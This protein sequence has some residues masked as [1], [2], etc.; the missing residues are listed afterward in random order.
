MEQVAIPGRRVVKQLTAPSQLAEEWRVAL[1]RQ[2][3]HGSKGIIAVVDDAVSYRSSRTS[4]YAIRR[5]RSWNRA[6]PA[7]KEVDFAEID[8]AAASTAA[9]AVIIEEK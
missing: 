5:Q 3:E 6:L 8:E 7:E 2:G 4:D 9:P 1:G